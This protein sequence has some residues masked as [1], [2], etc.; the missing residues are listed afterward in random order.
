MQLGLVRTTGSFIYENC[1]KGLL[2]QCDTIETNQQ[3]RGAVTKKRTDFSHECFN[4][5]RSAAVPVKEEW[6]KSSDFACSLCT[7]TVKDLCRIDSTNF[8]EEYKGQ[9]SLWRINLEENLKLLGLE[10]YDCAKVLTKIA[11]KYELRRK[12][13]FP[14]RKAGLYSGSQS[15]PQALFQVHT[16]WKIPT[17]QDWRL[18]CW[19]YRYIQCSN[20]HARTLTSSYVGLN[21]KIPSLHFYKKKMYR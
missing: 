21:N 9:L 4:F 13:I 20:H 14:T 1:S 12:V 6:S 3:I 8:C 7:C 2:S 17:K 19:F 16:V 15:E 10:I 18:L 11:Y 5:W